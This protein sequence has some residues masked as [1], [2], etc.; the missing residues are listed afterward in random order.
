M[1]ENQ[2]WNAPKACH[3]GSLKSQWGGLLLALTQ[4]PERFLLRDIL[5][6]VRPAGCCS[7]SWPSAIYFP[8][9]NFFVLQSYSKHG[10]ADKKTTLE[11]GLSLW[12]KCSMLTLHSLWI[13]LLWFTSSNI[14]NFQR[15]P[16]MTS[17]L[18]VWCLMLNF[19]SSWLGSRKATIQ[20]PQKGRE[21]GVQHLLRPEKRP[22]QR[23]RCDKGTD[24]FSAFLRPLQAFITTLIHRAWFFSSRSNT[25]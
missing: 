16:V 25:T 9:G 15:M 19:P 11:H 17:L 20:L 18:S 22:T 8:A 14:F 1:W 23:A 12:R 13:H 24:V 5:V 7:G 10:L 2:E 4:A 6:D 21:A 3:E